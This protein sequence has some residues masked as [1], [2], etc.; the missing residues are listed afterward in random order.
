MQQGA[1]NTVALVIA[2]VVG[3]P[4]AVLWGVAAAD[5]LQRTDGEF[6]SSQPSSSVRMFWTY[7]VLFFAGIG[8]LAYYF[9]VMKPYPR[10]RR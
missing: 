6:S 10:R 5:V 7:V 4:L 1:T 9:N 2:V 8:A 3:V